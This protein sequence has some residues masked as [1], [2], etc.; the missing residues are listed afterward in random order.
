MKHVDVVVSNN[1]VRLEGNYMF[2]KRF[3][4]FQ[5]KEWLDTNTPS[6][7]QTVRLIDR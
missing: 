4:I 3:R 6:G 1:Y 7:G 5:S 2:L